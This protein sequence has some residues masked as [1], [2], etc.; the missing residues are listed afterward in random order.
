MRVF[1]PISRRTGIEKARDYANVDVG[2]LI[3]NRNFQMT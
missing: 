1:Q 3:T 2:L